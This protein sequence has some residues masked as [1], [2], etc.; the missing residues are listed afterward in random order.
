MFQLL[1]FVLQYF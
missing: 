1:M